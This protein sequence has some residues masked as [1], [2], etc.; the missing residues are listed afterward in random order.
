MKVELECPI[1]KECERAENNVIYRCRAYTLLSG[2]MP[3]SDEVVEEW[4]CSIFEWLP[5]LLVENS[6]MTRGVNAAVASLR[7]ETLNKQDAAIRIIAS[8]IENAKI[9]NS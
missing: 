8:G 6:Q 4:R 3:T 5:I 2:K 1:G 7:D 9:T